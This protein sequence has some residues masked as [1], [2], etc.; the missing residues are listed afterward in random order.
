[1]KKSKITIADVADELGVSKT[2]V[3]RA[4]SGKGRIGEKTR[5][6]ILEY[7]KE[8]NYQPNNLA[9]GLAKS[10]TY[11][12]GIVMPEDYCATDAPFFVQSLASLH[13]VAVSKGYDILVTICNNE[14]MSNLERILLNRKVDGIVLMRSFVEDHAIKMLKEWN[15]PFVVI[16]SSDEEG[17]VQVDLDNE[18]GCQELTSILLMK[19]FERIALIGGNE[20]YTVTQKRMKG[21]K[22]AFEKFGKK[23]REELIFMNCEHMS[24]IERAVDRILKQGVDCIVCMD[25]NICMYVLNKLKKTGIPVPDQMK[26][27][28]FFNSKMLEQNMPSI[29]SLTFDVKNAGIVAC[30]TLIDLIQDKE[31][32]QFNQ[33]GYEVTLRESTK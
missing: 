15:M 24:A 7:I 19:K 29:T 16:G 3:S 23:P 25:Y 18:G 31:I 30:E 26:I 5:E 13:E 4:I 32:K 2:T 8:N 17:V 20:S 22:K 21:F 11:N 1:M 9:R 28:S 14:D 6:K 10:C 27:A 12:L 33:M